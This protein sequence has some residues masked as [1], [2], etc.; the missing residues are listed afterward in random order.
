[1]PEDRWYIR[2]GGQQQGPYSREQ[3]QVLI[4][5]GVFGRM[6]EVSPDGS[7]WARASTL[8]DLFAPPRS[9]APQ[10]QAAATQPS[11]APGIAAGGSATDYSLQRAATQP[12]DEPVMWYSSS[13]D[14]QNGPMSWEDLQAQAAAG[15][16]MPTDLVWT[17]GMPNWVPAAT[18]ADL[19]RMIAAP[20]SPAAAP[21]QRAIPVAQPL[22][23]PAS[24]P[25]SFAR[26]GVPAG[27]VSIAELQRMAAGGQLF[28]NDMVWQEGMPN[29]VPASSIDG[30][31][32]ASSA[33]FVRS[34]S[35]AAR[36]GRLRAGRGA[37]LGAVMLDGV[38]GL[39]SCIPGI[40]I[41]F[42]G[43]GGRDTSLAMLGLFLILVCA[44]GVA[45]YQ[46]VMLST[47]GQT[48]GKRMLSL[49]IVRE[50]DDGNPGFVQAVLVRAVVPGLITGIPGLGALFSL[51]DILFIFG[52]ERRCIHD[53]MAGTKVVV[54]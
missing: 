25:W 30:L 1:M 9:S 42:A 5:R 48:I 8:T 13:D 27:R 4:R 21:P 38:A 51:V 35:S 54:G 23:Q 52:D 26:G 37:R 24:N 12:S 34:T 33:K 50:L 11:A 6:H 31:F 44:L 7:S 45:I 22:H 43:A 32:A 36:E 29:W 18:I 28:P 19:Q 10:Q 14:V 20:S 17:E 49:R 46:C 47:Q 15:G 39:C 2:I 41:M 3:L 16:L 40:V 53:L